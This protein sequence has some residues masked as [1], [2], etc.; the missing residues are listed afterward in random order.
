MT[1]RVWDRFLTERDRAHL[2]RRSRRRL[3]WGERPGLLLID[4]YRWV[5]GDRP[6]P[7]LEAVEDWP[8]SCGLE[9]WEA[10]PHIQQLLGA[11]REAGIPVIHVTGL[12]GPGAPTP[13]GAVREGFSESSGTDP[14]ALDRFR[15]RFDIVD[16]VAPIE[17][18][19]VI[20][21]SSPSAFWG[22][23]LTGELT[24]RGI[25]T[26]IVAGE[27]TS[28]CVRASVVDGC[29]NRYRMVVVEECV[30][31]RH[32]AAHAMNLFD[33]NQKYADVVPLADAL[34]YL[35]RWKAERSQQTPQPVPA[36]VR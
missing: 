26:L 11:A 14:A 16:E 8:S 22:T 2:A 34:A 36:G 17:G 12:E 21:K 33:L 9:A 20:R 6:Q 35:Q 4:L 29:T 19:V 25:D 32:E 24:F 5:F 23:P 27:S 30:F 13:R 31:D 1:E 15:R 7:I 18:E 10:L 28:G 3:S